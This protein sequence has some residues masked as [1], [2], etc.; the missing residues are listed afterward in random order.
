MLTFKEFTMLATD[1]HGTIAEDNKPVAVISFGRMNPPTLGH[2]KL[3]DT[4]VSIAKKYNGKAMLFLSHSQDAKK[5]PLSYETKYKFV[6]KAA[7]SGLNVV[8]SQEKNIYTIMPTLGDMGYKK[9]VL[10]VGDDR[11]E[12]FKKVSKYMKDFKGVEEIEVVSAGARKNGTDVSNV[13]NIS[14]SLLRKLAGQNDK[15]TFIKGCIFAKKSKQDAE[16][17][18]KEVRNG[19]GLRENQEMSWEELNMLLSD[20]K[21]AYYGIDTWDASAYARGKVELS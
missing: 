9:V 21:K 11:V 13:E 15:E 19:L 5:N 18:Y 14:A 3:M 12:E 16:N 6:K 2:L 20:D 4:I 1:I 10:V 8:H 7:P 17:L